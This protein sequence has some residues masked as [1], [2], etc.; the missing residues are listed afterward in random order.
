MGKG[1]LIGVNWCA[2]STLCSLRVVGGF[3][4]GFAFLGGGGGAVDVVGEVHVGDAF[5]FAAE[6]FEVHQL[7]VV[8]GTLHA[9]GEGLDAAGV[10]AG[11]AAGFVVHG[12]NSFRFWARRRHARRGA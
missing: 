2:V 6:V 10:L 3:A 11:V 4:E 1:R 8:V 12:R 5:V 9:G 7:A